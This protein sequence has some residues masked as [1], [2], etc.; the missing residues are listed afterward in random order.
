MKKLFTILA[1]MTL[2]SFSNA[3]AKYLCSYTAYISEDDKYNS[4]GKHLG[5][6]ATRATAAA[7]L[8]QD[9][10]NT[11]RF[12]DMRDDIDDMDCYFDT[13][14]KRKR[15]AAM[16][17]KGSISKATINNIVMGN[18]TINVEVHSDRIHVT[19]Q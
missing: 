5:T 8:Q 19:T 7:I 15:M 11:H 13:T 14:A 17:Q 18:P 4:S 1:L 16:L 12:T 9:R 3:H 10:A 2:A 6:K